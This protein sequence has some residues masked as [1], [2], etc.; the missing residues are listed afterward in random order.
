MNR[1]INIHQPVNVLPIFHSTK[2]NNSSKSVTQQQEEH[3]YY[4]K[5][6][7]V[8]ADDHCQEEHL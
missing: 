5:E 6:A 8:H 2:Q 3:A 7:L 4:D 1:K